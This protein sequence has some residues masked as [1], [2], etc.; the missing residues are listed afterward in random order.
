MKSAALVVVLK[1][2]VPFLSAKK[3]NALDQIHFFLLISVLKSHKNLSEGQ[4]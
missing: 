3:Q 1:S 2:F 4:V